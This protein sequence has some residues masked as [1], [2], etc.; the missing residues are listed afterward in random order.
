[1]ENRKLK[2]KLSAEIEQTS[3]RFHSDRQAFMLRRVKFHQEE[4]KVLFLSTTQQQQLNEK[5]AI[6]NSNLHVK[7]LLFCSLIVN[8]KFQQQKDPHRKRK[9]SEKRLNCI[10]QKCNKTSVDL[11][12]VSQ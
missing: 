2:C 5:G 11:K 1:M 8:H 3:S 6:R 7:I 10:K 4:G 12:L 9:R